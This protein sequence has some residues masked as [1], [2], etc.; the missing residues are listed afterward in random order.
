MGDLAFRMLEA[1]ETLEEVSEVYDYINPEAA[2]WSADS[3]RHEA[4]FVAEEEQGEAHREELVEQLAIDL[5]NSRNP[6]VT[7]AESK[8]RSYWRDVARNV[9]DVG[10]RKR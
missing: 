5:F 8:Y 9:I 2:L 1:A 6:D 10:W 7:W 3:L 4:P